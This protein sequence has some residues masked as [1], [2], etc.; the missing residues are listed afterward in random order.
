M[1]DIGGRYDMSCPKCEDLGVI[2]CKFGEDSCIC[3]SLGEYCYSEVRLGGAGG[4]VKVVLTS[5]PC[6]ILAAVHLRLRYIF[7]KSL[8]PAL[9]VS[10]RSSGVAIDIAEVSLA[11]D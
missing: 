1:A 4:W 3:E 6:I 2:D 7:S 9:G 5:P 11:V 8:H 10:I